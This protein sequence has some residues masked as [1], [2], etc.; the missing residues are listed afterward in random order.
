MAVTTHR[1]AM[2]ETQPQ[3]TL[4]PRFVQTPIVVR[5]DNLA[6]RTSL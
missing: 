6:R 5:T 2:G 3:T 4:G 1:L